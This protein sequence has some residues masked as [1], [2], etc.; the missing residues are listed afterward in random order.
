M[1]DRS[2]VLK[3]TDGTESTR[4]ILEDVLHDMTEMVRA[5]VKLARSEI[6]DDLRAAGQSAGMF[7]GAALCGALAAACITTCIIA[8]LAL[9]LPLWAAAIITAAF[10]G[11]IGAICYAGGRARI[12]ASMPPLEETRNKVRSDYQWLK[13]QTR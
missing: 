10:V 7:G 5:E 2:D 9:V 4:G 1:G 6:K 8:L 3:R 12:R 11:I 13:Q